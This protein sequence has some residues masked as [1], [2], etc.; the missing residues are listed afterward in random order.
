VEKKHEEE[1]QKQK[2]LRERYNRINFRTLLKDK[3]LSGEIGY[4]TKWRQFV[5]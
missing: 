5:T 1:L 2:R 3:L 4:K